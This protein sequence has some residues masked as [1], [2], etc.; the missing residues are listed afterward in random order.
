MKN[1]F[2]QKWVC[3]YWSKTCTKITRGSLSSHCF[4]IWFQSKGQ[5]KHFTWSPDS[6]IC[7]YTTM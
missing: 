7:R 1:S 2:N 5:A 3:W 6:V 4:S